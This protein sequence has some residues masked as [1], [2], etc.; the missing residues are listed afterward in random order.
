MVHDTKL[1]FLVDTVNMAQL[2][3]TPTPNDSE[4]EC[5]IKSENEN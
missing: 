1:E 2:G 4:L 3:Y 5:K